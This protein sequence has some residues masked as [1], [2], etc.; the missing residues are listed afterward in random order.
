VLKLAC[1]AKDVAR[2]REVLGL[3]GATPG[4]DSTPAPT[5]GSNSNSNSSG[6]ASADPP[7]GAISVADLSGLADSVKRAAFADDK[8]NVIR[9]ACKYYQFSAAQAG[10]IVELIA[11]SG[12]QKRAA[13][14]LFKACLDKEHFHRDVVMRLKFSSDR[15]ELAKSLGLF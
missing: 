14:T 13:E 8:I 4:S 9:A 7:A 1:P 3:T 6:S 11:M 10:S 2:A 5:A 15:D 12:D